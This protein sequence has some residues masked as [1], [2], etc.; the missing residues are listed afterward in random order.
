MVI[1]QKWVTKKEINGT[2]MH[3]KSAK[4]EKNSEEYEEVC[5]IQWMAV[6]YDGTED[7][8]VVSIEKCQYV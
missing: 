4:G 6:C 1:L 8:A 5:R 3:I 7:K 2:E